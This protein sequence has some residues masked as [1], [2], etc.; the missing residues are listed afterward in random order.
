[1]FS[2]GPHAQGFIERGGSASADSVASRAS[3]PEELA[4]RWRPPPE[5]RKR[6]Q[7]DP[8]N[9]IPR[10]AESRAD[11]DKR[12]LAPCADTVAEAQHIGGTR[13]EQAQQLRSSALDE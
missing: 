4:H 1:M 8:S 7:L 2:K 6:L 3:I 5:F 11:L 13:V 10:Q 12:V 9:T